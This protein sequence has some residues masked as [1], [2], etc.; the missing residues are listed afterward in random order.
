LPGR[1]RAQR[2]RLELECDDDAEVAA[3]TA[4]CP[5][6]VWLALR[7][8][9]PKRTV[10]G[11]DVDADERIDGETV[12]PAQPSHPAAQGEAACS[13][14]RYDASRNDEAVRQRDA[15]DVTEQRAAPHDA[16]PRDRVDRHPVERGQLQHEPTVARRVPREA[17]TTAPNAQQNVALR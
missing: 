5:E 3:S 13:G 15:V 11:D 12:E 16:A 7:A 9:A 17:M 6:Q 2:V 4:Q 8:R 1:D 14:V 10:G